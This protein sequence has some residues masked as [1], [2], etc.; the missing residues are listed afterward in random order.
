MANDQLGK[1]NATVF[2]LIV[3]GILGGATVLTTRGTNGLDWR[4][5]NRYVSPLFIIIFYLIIAAGLCF[6]KV[7]VLD[8]MDV[9]DEVLQAAGGRASVNNDGAFE[10]HIDTKNKWKLSTLTVSASIARKDGSE[11][12]KQTIVLRCF[13][14][15]DGDTCFDFTSLRR[16]YGDH[17]SWSI[18]SARGKPNIDHPTTT[19]VVLLVVLF[20][21]VPVGMIIVLL[22]SAREAVQDEA[23]NKA[24]WAK[25]TAYYTIIYLG[26][27]LLWPL[28]LNSWF[29][30]PGMVEPISVGSANSALNEFIRTA[31]GDSAKRTASLT[32]SV[33]LAYQS[34]LGGVVDKA[35]IRSKA[36]ELL[37]SSI[38]YSTPDLAISV[39]LNFY[40]RDELTE[41]LSGAQIGARVQLMEWLQNG[42]VN[43]VL[44]KAFEATLYEKFKR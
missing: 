44:A 14:R 32:E 42:T 18:V 27:I 22:T 23:V 40:K 28:F 25:R 37:Q 26:G 30:G 21:Y 6:T 13:S 19:E 29:S 1:L 3:V 24:V 33:E 9:P 5:F 4:A 34:L 12:P 7:N 43:A 15:A 36:V 41:S 2:M 17:V 39:A 10:A 16:Q 35:D 8:V 38:P 11:E 31:Y 20:V